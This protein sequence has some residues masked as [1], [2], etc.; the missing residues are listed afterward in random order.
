M[1]FADLAGFGTRY[2]VTVSSGLHSTNN[3]PGGTSLEKSTIFITT[4]A[5]APAHPARTPQ[6]ARNVRTLR[7]DAP[8]KLSARI[9]PR[10]THCVFR[11][12]AG[13]D[14]RG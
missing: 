2:M 13:S 3:F 11:M 4:S 8:P 9:N 10:T 5:S 14:F 6:H 1:A 12:M 7:I